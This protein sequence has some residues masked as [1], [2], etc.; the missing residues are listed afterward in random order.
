MS[1]SMNGQPFASR[2]LRAPLIRVSRLTLLASEARA[3]VEAAKARGQI[4]VTAHQCSRVG[5]TNPAPD[6]GRLCDHCRRTTCSWGQK[7]RQVV[8]QT[9]VCGT[10]FQ[11]RASNRAWCSQRCYIR[12]KR[13]AEFTFYCRTCGTRF[14]T[15]RRSKVYCSDCSGRRQQPGSSRAEG[16]HV[17][18][19]RNAGKPP[20]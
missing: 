1:G 11:T 4:T 8:E 9:C 13:R 17:S 3:I 7:N 16:R 5:C 18:A 12:H 6:V 14:T 20:A 15:T 10:A 19:A 2:S